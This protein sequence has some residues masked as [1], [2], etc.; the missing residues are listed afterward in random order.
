M[1]KSFRSARASARIQNVIR[2]CSY[3]KKRVPKVI[4]SLLLAAVL[5]FYSTVESGMLAKLG[6]FYLVMSIL[7]LLNAVKE[8]FLAI[9]DRTK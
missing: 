6:P 4:V 1:L 5:Y 8:I 9:K 7:F 3:G 2:R